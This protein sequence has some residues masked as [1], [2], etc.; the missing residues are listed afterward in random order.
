MT[1]D[2]MS[3]DRLGILHGTDKAST[4]HGFLETYEQFFEPLRHKPLCLLEIGVK[5]GASVRTWADYFPQARI[6]GLDFNPKTA[7][8]ATD[9]ITIEIGDQSD[10]AVL[11]GL[12]QRYGPFDIVIEDGSHLWQHQILGLETLFEHVKPGGYY[13]M[14]DIHTS[15]GEPAERYHGGAAFSAVDYL[16]R[17]A[18]I[19]MWSDRRKM[20]QSRRPID[21]VARLTRFVCLTRHAAVIRRRG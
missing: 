18:E 7:A 15:F 20:E 12:C 13:V 17:L 9:R 6:V 8:Q 3:L 1:P 16:Q 2:N 19:V 4:V 10:R 5:D 11:L 14:E 21:Q